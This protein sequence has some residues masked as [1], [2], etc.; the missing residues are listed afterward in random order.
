M[1][2]KIGGVFLGIFLLMIFT[3]GF[4][5]ALDEPT[6]SLEGKFNTVV[7]VYIN[8][9]ILKILIGD[10]S[11]DASG[12][13]FLIK[14]LFFIILI[15]LIY[16]GVRVIP[17]IQDKTW[18]VWIISIVFSMIA[19]R[20]ISQG[21]I[22]EF[23]WLPTGVMGITIATIIPFIIFFFFIEKTFDSVTIRKI[24]W[25]VFAVIYTMLALIRWD[26]LVMKTA[27]G[28]LPKGFSLG[29]FYVA[30]AVLSIIV[31]MFDPKMRVIV[32]RAKSASARQAVIDVEISKH[33]DKIN[34][35]RTARG[36]HDPDSTEY[37]NFDKQIK[38]Q[39][40]HIYK[41]QKEKASLS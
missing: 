10:V 20:Y 11:G 25:S 39:E 34:E 15:A 31:M 14:I 37:K 30:I 27:N 4:V 16:Y 5:V 33:T 35:Y 1:N 17:T 7:D 12:E 13:L 32:L 41:L 19:I 26:A 29:W 23:L 8:N 28:A 38:S 21:E 6:D 2:K 24:G 36:D 3:S 9:P 22:I 40:K 18:L